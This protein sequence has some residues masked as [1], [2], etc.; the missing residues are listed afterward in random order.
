MKGST[1]FQAWILAQDIGQCQAINRVISDENCFTTDTVV[2]REVKK[3]FITYLDL[4]TYKHLVR[5][6]LSCSLFSFY[7]NFKRQLTCTVLVYS[8]P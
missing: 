8:N 7:E 5:I 2:R 6:G 3:K 1:G 4:K